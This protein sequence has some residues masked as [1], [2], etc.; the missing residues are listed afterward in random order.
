MTKIRT[1]EGKR[2]SQVRIGEVAR[3]DLQWIAVQIL[4][5]L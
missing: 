2:I 5:L 3:V 4:R 1:Q